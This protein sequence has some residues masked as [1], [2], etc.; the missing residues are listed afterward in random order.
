MAVDWITGER[1][2]FNVYSL[3]GAETVWPRGLPLEY[4]LHANK[5]ARVE[6]QE[7]RALIVQSL[8]NDNP[9]VDAVFRMT[10]LLPVTFS[11][12]APVALRPGTWCPFNSQATLFR[13]EVFPLL[14]LPSCCSFRMTDIWRSF[15]AQRCLWEMGD[16]VVFRAPDVY[17]ERNDHNL[18]RDFM[19]EV[20]GYR[21][22]EAIRLALES[23]KVD[24][25]DL[26]ASMARCYETLVEKTFVGADELQIL[27]R[28]R[29]ALD[30]S[31]P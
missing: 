6:R 24:K 29:E 21:H 28:W 10:R 5:A 18:L 13:Q 16:G 2:W 27:R 7:S 17:Q 3:F 14:Y 11:N 31:H 26:H 19:D 25:H 15:V 22:N 4:V 12:R 1:P 8:A 30:N 20:P 23:C 9:D